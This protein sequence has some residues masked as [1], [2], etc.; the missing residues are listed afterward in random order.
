[1]HLGVSTRSETERSQERM[2]SQ[3]GPRIGEVAMRDVERLR[4]V[5]IASFILAMACP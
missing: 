5:A 2:A 4:T 1:M 3:R